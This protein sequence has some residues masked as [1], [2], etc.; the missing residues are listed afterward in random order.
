[1]IK[2]KNVFDIPNDL[3][4]PASMNPVPDKQNNAMVAA[5]TGL[6]P[7]EPANLASGI[8]LEPR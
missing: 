5:R 1:M 8:L 3:E 4:K 2:T 7:A 6:R